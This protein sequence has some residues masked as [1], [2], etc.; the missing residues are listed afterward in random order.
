M[1]KL[2]AILIPTLDSRAKL[3]N[4]LLDILAPQ[5]GADIEVFTHRD[6]GSLPI[7]LK[8]NGLVHRAVERDFRF[9]CFIDDDDTV[10]GNY[11]DTIRAALEG[12]PDVVELNGTMTRDGGDPLPFHHS[13]KYPAYRA[14]PEGVWRSPNHLNPQR[15]SIMAQVK[16]RPTNFGEDSIFARGI[17]PL[18]KTEAP[19]SEVTYN[20]IFR[21]NKKAGE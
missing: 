18:L 13:I 14:T 11:A 19:T 9:A 1:P 21:S 7:G 20:Y 16:F 5:L 2:L 12:D 17:L 8:R 6:D 4:R 15:L 10:T 3:L